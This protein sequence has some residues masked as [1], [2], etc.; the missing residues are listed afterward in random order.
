MRSGGWSTLSSPGRC[1]WVFLADCR[2]WASFEGSVLN[3]AFPLYL[4]GRCAFA[5]S[6]LVM[7][8]SSR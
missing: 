8:I 3:P 6:G 4:Y 5:T 2:L 1:T 7:E